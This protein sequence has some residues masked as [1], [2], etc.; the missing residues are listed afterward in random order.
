MIKPHEWILAKISLRV[1]RTL[2]I[3]I[4]AIAAIA[5]F[6]NVFRLGPNAFGGQEVAEAHIT[7]EGLLRVISRVRVTRCPDNV[8]YMPLRLP[9]EGAR[10]EAVAVGGRNI[11]FKSGQVIPGA[12]PNTYYAMPSLPENALRDALV[13]V[14]WSI[15]LADVR[16]GEGVVRFPLQGIIPVRSFAANLI[17]DEGAPYK[18]GGKFADENNLNMF[19]TKMD[20]YVEGTLGWCNIEILDKQY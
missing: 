13:E 6:N 2:C 10:L 17:L 20:K 14:T 18:L 16:T 3:A 7:P 12:P 19:W 9:Q 1:L 11:P 15:P 4:L 8:A 5:I